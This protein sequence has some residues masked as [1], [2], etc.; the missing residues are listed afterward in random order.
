MFLFDCFKWFFWIVNEKC[1]YDDAW[2]W[3]WN[4]QVITNCI[5]IF[6]MKKWHLFWTLSVIENSFENEIMYISW[7]YQE[8]FSRLLIQFEWHFSV[9]NRQFV[10]MKK[11][12]KYKF[13][14]A[15]NAVIEWKKRCR[16]M[17]IEIKWK[18]KRKRN[19]KKFLKI[20][21]YE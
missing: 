10:N 15:K 13:K 1:H 3:F 17:K 12:I 11:K 18:K 7:W 8:Q 5:H 14:T 20:Q 9:Q 16:E 19:K 2:Q 4:S 6:R 21:F